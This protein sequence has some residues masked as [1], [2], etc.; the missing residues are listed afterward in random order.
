[1][2]FSDILKMCT[3][4]LKRRKGRTI[5]TVLGV[6]IGCTSII[7]M[8]SIGVGMK[9]SQDQM[10]SEMGDLSIIEVSQMYGD[11][12]AAKLDDDAVESFRQMAGV[13]AVM[14]KVNFNEY[15]V[16]LK[17]GINDRYYCDWS[18]VVGLDTDAMEAMGF[19][20]MEGKV[21][22]VSTDE[23]VGG[24]YLAYNFYD[25]LMPDGHNM[26]NRWDIYDENGN[27]KE[28]PDPFFDI[29]KTPLTL[30]INTGENGDSVFRKTIKITGVTKEDYG[31]GWETS[32]G[33]MMSIDAMKALLKDIKG[34]PQ[35]NLTY[36][37]ILVKAEDI[38]LVTSIEE[39]ISGLG[40]YTYS[41]E[42]MRESM[43]KSARQVQLMLGGLG[44]ISLFVA[45]IGITNTMVM[46]ISER[47][48]EIG[49]MKA[50]G[51]YV[52][53]IRLMFLMEAGAIGLL[54]GIAGVLF[55]LLISVGINLVAMG[56]LSMGITGQAILD[57]LLGGEG[58]TRIS[59]VS[60]G[61]I[62]FAIVFSIFVGVASGY[63]PANK[64]VK[65]SALEAIKRE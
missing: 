26:V 41:M 49:I 45:A 27:E 25:S 56:A 23:A 10:L 57:A 35:K 12:S 1:M 36:S 63:Y 2:S 61:L 19:E 62:V 42:S 50:L 17:A 32:E 29:L 31:K 39:E 9:E 37:T 59:V 47:T 60:P 54:G 65:I 28:L 55:S 51:C 18:N 38:S 21:P 13:A 33:I 8:V 16:S 22:G 15:A 64:A 5:L 44:A 24:Q 14:P 46:S 4:N 52:K 30:E 34:T 3:D 53:D 7:V 48:R 58:I 6:F 43:E 11:D 40:Y 20:I